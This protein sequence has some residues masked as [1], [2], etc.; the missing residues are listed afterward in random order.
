MILSYHV[1]SE[2]EITPCIKIEQIF[3]K[4][5][6]VHSNVAYIITNNHFFKQKM[7]FQSNL[8]VT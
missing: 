6:D 1:A 2:S 3:G 8:N 7:G 4:G 5:H